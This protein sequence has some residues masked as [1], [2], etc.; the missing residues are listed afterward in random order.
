MR[1]AGCQILLD[2][3]GE[4]FIVHFFCY[5]YPVLNQKYVSIPCADLRALPSCLD[6]NVT[7][8][9]QKL[10]ILLLFINKMIENTD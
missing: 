7:N 1:Y 4:T 2:T 9:N 10:N 3:T 5:I 8:F 6:E